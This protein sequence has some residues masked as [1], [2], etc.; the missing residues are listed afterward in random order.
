MAIGEQQAALSVPARVVPVPSS[1]SAEAQG[2]LAMGPM[3]GADL[4]ALDDLEG[5]RSYVAAADAGLV[6]M[7]G[8]LAEQARAEVTV[9]DVGGVTVHD[10]R[11]DDVPADDQ[12]VV[13]EI[14]GGALIMGGGAACP[15]MAL[16]AVSGL[17]RRMWAVDYRMPPDH[18]YPAGLDDC[19]TV[20]R[21]LLEEHRPDQI[22]VR[23]GSAGANLGAAL[24]LRARDEGLPLPAGAILATPEVD[25]TESG[26]S[27]QTNLG[28]DTVLTASLM[29]Q[30]LLYAGGH[31]LADPYLSPLF[32]DFTRGFPRTLLTAGTRDLFLSNAVRMHRSLRSAGVE[33]ELHVIEAGPH[34]AFFGMTPEDR[35]I[36]AEVRRFLAGVW[37]D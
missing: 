32:G 4:P 3:V 6:A 17:R 26:D 13:L 34:G 23:G 5:W 24:I 35:A 33:A 22:V 11:P 9:L 2:V 15:L 12:H 30:N 18:P 1:I 25:L 27:F 21:A 29:A 14:H 31:D 7:M 16:G 36:E 19:L 10:I 37:A 28:V 8:G 20:Y